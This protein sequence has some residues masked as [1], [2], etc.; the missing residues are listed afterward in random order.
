MQE[1]LAREGLSWVSNAG[2][3]D[4]MASQNSIG[5]SGVHLSGVPLLLSLQRHLEMPGRASGIGEMATVL[6]LHP[7]R[8][9]LL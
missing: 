2:L 6:L 4:S 8:L 7:T 1:Y 5:C 9:A 3:P